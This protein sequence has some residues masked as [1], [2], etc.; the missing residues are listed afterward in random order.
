MAP[1]EPRFT[2]DRSRRQ[3]SCTSQ[4]KRTEKELPWLV[5]PKGQC[6]RGACAGGM[7][8]APDGRHRPDRPP[9]SKSVSRGAGQGE[10]E[11]GRIVQ[12]RAQALAPVSVVRKMARLGAEVETCRIGR[13]IRAG[14]STRTPAKKRWRQKTLS[15]GSFDVGSDTRGD[16]AR[17]HLGWFSPARSTCCIT[18][19][20]RDSPPGHVWGIVK[21]SQK[22]NSRLA[23]PKRATAI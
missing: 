14:H 22:V 6:S 3:P 20:W 2:T 9:Y 21:R 13:D 8:R 11:S 5:T 1:G 15:R 12:L 17:P 4:R 19:K 18:I 10:G 7:A 16:P 23:L